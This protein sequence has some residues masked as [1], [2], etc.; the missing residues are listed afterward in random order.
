MHRR[1][2]DDCT[3]KLRSALIQT[4]PVHTGRYG[5]AADVVE[6][7]MQTMVRAPRFDR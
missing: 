5:N 2:A 4:S 6:Y 7:L 1:I 3:K